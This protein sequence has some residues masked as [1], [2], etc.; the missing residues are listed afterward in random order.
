MGRGLAGAVLRN[1]LYDFWKQNVEAREQAKGVNGR[2]PKSELANIR[3]TDA[4]EQL[5]QVLE[6]V[7]K[8]GLSVKQFNELYHTTIDV[9]AWE[10]QLANK[11]FRKWACQKGPHGRRRRLLA[12]ARVY[13][14]AGQGD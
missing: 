14:L 1:L 5:L 13:A 6:E 12:V 10:G 9:A 7:F 3:K 4:W 11:Q 8:T 2:I